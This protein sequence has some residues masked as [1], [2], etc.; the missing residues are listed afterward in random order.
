[1]Y[2]TR[3]N[4]ARIRSIEQLQCDR[5]SVLAEAQS[6]HT[7]VGP[8]ANPIQDLQ[9]TIWEDDPK[10]TSPQVLRTS[11]V[12]CEKSIPPPDP[13]TTNRLLGRRRRQARLPHICGTFQSSKHRHAALILQPK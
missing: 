2:L 6:P 3:Q 9:N 4:R 12:C 1:M 7:G 5:E 13:P 11:T 10:N 8:A